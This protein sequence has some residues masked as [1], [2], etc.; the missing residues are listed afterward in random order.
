MFRKGENYN[1][2]FQFIENKRGAG[3]HKETFLMQQP[4]AGGSPGPGPVAS[5]SL[6]R[7]PASVSRNLSRAPSR[8]EALA[9]F[10]ND[11]Q[12]LIPDRDCG[13]Q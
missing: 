13:G 12:L 1:C 2:I 5:H 4:S 9:D 11:L 10:C 7:L 8:G 3:G 6:A